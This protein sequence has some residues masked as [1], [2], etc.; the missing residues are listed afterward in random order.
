MP[1]KLYPVNPPI[2]PNV[3]AAIMEEDEPLTPEDIATIHQRSMEA[4]N[5]MVTLKDG[6]KRVACTQ[7]HR[8]PLQ[9]ARLCQECY[10]ERMRIADWKAKLDVV[11][12]GKGRPKVTCPWCG[13]TNRG[14]FEGRL[15]D[16]CCD[17]MGSA[18]KQ[19]Y[20]GETAYQRAA[21]HFEIPGGL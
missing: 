7:C 20:L 15:N 10:D 17:E 3:K 6:S 11:R 9:I 16:S 18:L 12:R 14:W 8:R 1:N 19:I 21:D 2:D 13:H 4:T 5:P